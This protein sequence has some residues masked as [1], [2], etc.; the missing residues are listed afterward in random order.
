MH[1]VA[2]NVNHNSRTLDGC[3]TF[4]GMCIICSV[5]PAVSSSFTIPCLEGLSTEDLI[6]FTKIEQKMLPSSRKPLKL[7][8]IELNKPVN[9]FD[10]LSSAWAAMWLLNPWQPLWSGYMQTVNTGNHPPVEHQ[11]FSCQ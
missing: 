10:P 1:H 6:R 2:D 11:H 7:K 9:A 8:F 5:T 4:H 3:K